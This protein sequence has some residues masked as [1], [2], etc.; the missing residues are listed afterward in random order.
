MPSYLYA[1]PKP[2]ASPT[3]K[4][5]RPSLR[6]GHDLPNPILKSDS[7]TLVIAV[8]GKNSIWMSTD[9]RLSFSHSYKDHARKVLFLHTTDGYAILGYAGLGTARGTEPSDWMA[10]VLRG[11]NMPL[12][13]SLCVLADAVGNKIPKFLKRFTPPIPHYI[14]IPAFLNGEPRMYSIDL[15]C[16]PGQSKY[17]FRCT[18]H[19][20]SLPNGQVTTSRIAIAGSGAAHL[21]H[22]DPWARKLLRIVSAYDAGRITP[23]AVASKFAYYNNYVAE[24]DH[25]V[26]KR[27][28][29]T[30]RSLKG[31]GPVFL[32]NGTKKEKSS[33]S[34]AIPRIVCGRDM[35]AVLQT[36]MPFAISSLQA[37]YQS[38]E[39][40]MDIERINAELAKLP[41]NPD[42][43]F[44]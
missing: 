13:Q 20:R 7:M 11:L 9:R 24:E 4:K 22:A 29:V 1:P 36:L 3:H 5:I 23:Q 35:N 6:A 39:T 40:K 28:I 10:R 30:H 27:C 17:W 14:I 38:G 32:F 16:P 12:E 41:E 42:D 34:D 26:G 33:L 31:G 44:P 8:T 21:P 43:T 37:S 19:V 18:R 25:A 2:L 15:V